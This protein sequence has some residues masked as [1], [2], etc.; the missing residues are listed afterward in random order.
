[1]WKDQLELVLAKKPYR[2]DRLSEIVIQQTDILSFLTVPSN[3]SPQT[4]PWTFVFLSAVHAAVSRIEFRIKNYFSSPR[5]NELTSEVDPV[6]QTPA[7]SSYPSGHAT[8]SFCLARVLGAICFGGRHSETE[9]IAMRIAHNREFA[10]VHFP[11][12]SIEGAKLGIWVGEHFLSKLKKLDSASILTD[13][14]TGK[15]DNWDKIVQW[16]PIDKSAVGNQNGNNSSKN[17][18]Q[19]EATIL[20]WIIYELNNE[21][22]TH[23]GDNA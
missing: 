4:H 19:K 13:N 6:I 22:G 21:L 10:G 8:E 1:M 7:H 23:G 18:S 5:P 14:R 3:I 20:D 12:D 15:V 16:E 17:Q 2:N 11:I 9:Q